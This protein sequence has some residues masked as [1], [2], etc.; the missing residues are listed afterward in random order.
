[1]SDNFLNLIPVSPSFVPDIIAQN[2]AKS[3]LFQRYIDNRIEFITTDKIEFVDQGG[4][5]DTVSCNL[6]GHALA[7]EVWQTAMDGAFQRQFDDL[8]FTTPCCNKITSL[9]D[10]KYEMP[11]GFARY[12]MRIA[13]PQTGLSNDEISKL[14][15]VV[16][17]KLKIV[18]AH[19]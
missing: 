14:E 8:E 5:F 3:F 15:G 10:L 16:G 11:A 12:I 2:N 13:N 17:S 7:S 6:C 4:N 19:Y 9:N 18:W 1:M